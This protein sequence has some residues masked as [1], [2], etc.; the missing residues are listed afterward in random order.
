MSVCESSSI[1]KNIFLFI[2]LRKYPEF[3]I[4]FF[5]VNFRKRYIFI[6]VGKILITQRYS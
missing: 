1:Q 3:T 6:E 4:Y 2:T 5:R